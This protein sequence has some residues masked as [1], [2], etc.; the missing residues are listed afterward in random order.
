MKFQIIIVVLSVWLTACSSAPE[1]NKNK[2]TNLS[3]QGGL[4]I[5]QTRCAVCHGDAGQGFKDL[6]PPIAGS[7]YLIKNKESVPCII[8]NGLEGEITVNGKVY[9]S[10]MLSHTDLTDMELADLMTFIYNSWEMNEGTFSKSD[11]KNM[12]DNCKE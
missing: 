5:Y 7:D 1:E 10:K 6:Y 4:E 12:L 2:F 11:I 8:K 3:Y 9:N